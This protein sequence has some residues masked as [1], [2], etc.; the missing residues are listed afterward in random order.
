VNACI[1]DVKARRPPSNGP[2]ESRRAL[3][4]AKF[5]IRTKY[6]LIKL[7]KCWHCLLSSFCSTDQKYVN[8]VIRKVLHLVSLKTLEYWFP[9]SGSLKPN[10]RS[11][12]CQIWHYQTTVRGT[13][14]L[15]H[16]ALPN[17]ALP[18]YRPWPSQNWHSQTDWRFTAKL[19]CMTL[20][21]LALP[22]CRTLHC[23]TPVRDTV[24]FGTAILPNVALPKFRT[25][26][27]HNENFQTT[28]RGTANFPYVA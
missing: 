5:F 21:N 9:G 14:K 27:C 15:P 13:A 4:N 23:P 6:E 16:L 12:H 18:N 17:W 25:W 2:Q 22:H 20:L 19:Q 8:S 10:N 1:N 28:V 26:Y 3:I 7:F 11:W 24:K